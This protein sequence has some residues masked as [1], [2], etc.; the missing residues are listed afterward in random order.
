MSVAIAYQRARAFSS[1]KSSSC[2][3]QIGPALRAACARMIPMTSWTHPAV[4]GN[5]T[6]RLLWFNL[7]SQDVGAWA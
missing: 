1:P 4:D 2:S 3:L 5:L 7:Y 6:T